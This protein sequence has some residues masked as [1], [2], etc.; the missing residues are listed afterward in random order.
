MSA[1]FFQQFRENLS[2]QNASDIS[3]SYASIT[4]RLNK[5]FWNQ[6]S[7]VY[8]RR[9]VG[10]YGRKTAIHGI[11]DLD[12]V[13][14]LPW[15]LYERYK[16]YEGNGPSQLLQAVRK[17]LQARYRKTEIKGDGQVVVI[18]F[19]KFVVEVLPAFVDKECDGYRFGD[20]NN[21]GSWKLCKPVQEMDAVDQRNIATN[22]NLKHVCK[23]LRAW[24][25]THGVNMGGLLIDTLA[26]NFFG[27]N[28]EYNDKSYA[29]YDK[30]FV[31]LFTYLGGLDHQDYWAAPGSGQRV[32]SKGKFQSK[33]KKAA[34]KCQEA[35]ETDKEK[36]KVKLWREVFGRSFPTE[37]VTSAKS[38]SVAQHDTSRYTTEQFI[39]D[40]Y[41]VDI[42]FDLTIDSDVL[43]EGANA[44]R[45]R[46][47]AQRFFWLPQGRSLRFHV[48]ECDV[49]RPYQLMWKIR[50]VGTEAERRDC[51]RGQIFF[52][53]GK[54][55]QR[56]RTDFHGEHFV[57]AY[58]IKDGV[59][60]A[61]DVIDVRINQ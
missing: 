38:E 55:E 28:S 56:E 16:A 60:V 17:S 6:E 39:E 3:T 9:Q 48:V 18:E 36:K 10:S 51:I 49:P 42:R 19:S 23:M 1:A 29:A 24:K 15:P 27:Q 32:H 50:N 46:M 43:H 59:C 52:D 37:I 26:Y 8:H 13:F 22:R 12:M 21:G 25:N 5:D 54:Q 34:A 45:L 33:A 58:V 57:E 31:A 7:D 11:S 41:P 40:M 20:A 14:E 47:L 4:T 30:L 35:L 44:G 53:H 61:R 2:V